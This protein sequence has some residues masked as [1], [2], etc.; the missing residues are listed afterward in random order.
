MLMRARLEKAPVVVWNDVMLQSLGGGGGGSNHFT[1]RHPHGLEELRRSDFCCQSIFDCLQLEMLQEM[2]R[3]GEDLQAF[4]KALQ[5][6]HYK[7]VG[8]KACNCE[9]NE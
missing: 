2:M 1:Y 7:Q 5:G 3:T 6:R 4:L 9:Q 8:G